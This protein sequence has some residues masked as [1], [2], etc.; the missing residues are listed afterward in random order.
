MFTFFVFLLN[1]ARSEDGGPN[2]G[3]Y[4][5]FPSQPYVL[6]LNT[7]NEEIKLSRTA[8]DLVEISHKDP[9][10]QQWSHPT[11]IYS[12]QMQSGWH[13]GYDYY[14]D[15]NKYV[16]ATPSVPQKQGECKTP[17]AE[18]ATHGSWNPN[19]APMTFGLSQTAES[20]KW[21]SDHQQPAWNSNMAPV[22]FAA[23]GSTTPAPEGMVFGVTSGKSDD[24]A[25]TDNKAI[26]GAAT[27]T[28]GSKG[29]TT[30]KG[31]KKT[32]KSGSDDGNGT[33]KKGSKSNK[34]STDSKKSSGT[35]PKK[36]NAGNGLV[37]L[38][39]IATVITVTLTMFFI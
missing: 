27:G 19:T 1:L 11:P 6:E 36:K 12:E 34:K 2:D 16:A 37:I 3:T 21:S 20:Q 5:L 38:S 28:A 25:G 15:S 10:T 9:Y 23:V 29:D 14:D 22:T 32:S 39:Y 33:S 30:S 13:G 8:P 35:K 24:K 18:A 7:P 17:A 4:Y 31:G 26:V